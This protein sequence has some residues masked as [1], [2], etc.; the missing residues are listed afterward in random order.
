MAEQKE[1]SAKIFEYIPDLDAF[2][3]T[4]EY[5]CIARILHLTEWNP[6]VWIGRYFALDNDYGEHWFDNHD[7]RDRVVQEI[8]KNQPEE[9]MKIVRE[10]A[11]DFGKTPKE[12][13]YNLADKVLKEDYS[14]DSHEQLLIIDP[15]CFISGRRRACHS[16]EQRKRFWTDV[17]K[18]LNL[19]LETIF[20]EARENY[21][22]G[23]EFHDEY[24]EVPFNEINIERR[25]KKIKDKFSQK[26]AKLD[27]QR[28]W[29]FEYNQGIDAFTA[30]EEYKEIAYALKLNED[31][32]AIYQ[33]N[34]VKWI[35]RLFTRDQDY[36][37]LWFENWQDREFIRDDME[38]DEIEF[39]NEKLREYYTVNPDRFCDGDDGPCHY[40]AQRKKFWK[41]VLKSLRL[42]LDTL[43]EEARA[44]YKREL[45]LVKKYPHELIFEGH[46]HGKEPFDLE[47]KIE[48]IKAIYT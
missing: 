36:G 29:I 31:R 19:S 2:K 7:E 4:R 33:G 3:A 18:S 17:C 12:I 38:M 42:S 11:E 35:G 13:E 20:D 28:I 44:K 16:P 30:T 6:V 45:E 15:S 27:K 34:P 9:P 23:K 14:V 25:I 26:E 32:N 5:E 24:S 46:L 39:D 43:F 21:E 1:K 8:I 37:E 40:S 22:A 10:L 48:E 47:K 41:D